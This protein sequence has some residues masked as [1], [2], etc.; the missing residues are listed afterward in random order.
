MPAKP[1]AT[2]KPLKWHRHLKRWYGWG[3][4]SL[5]VL[6]LA[7][8]F[9]GFWWFA[10]VY[11]QAHPLNL[12]AYLPKFERFMAKRGTPVKVGSAELYFDGGPVVRMDDIALMGP[13]GTMAVYVEQAGI[14]LANRRLLLL[15]LSPKVIE[16]QNVTLRLVADNG[17]MSV[18]GMH[19]ASDSNTPM[20]SV[21]GWLNGLTHD[22]VWGRLKT[23]RVAN[24]NLLVKDVQ[25]NTEWV[26]ER[27]DLNIDR[28]P[29]VGEDGTLNG[30]V[31]RLQDGKTMVVQEAGPRAGPVGGR[32]VG[33]SGSIV[34]SQ[35]LAAVTPTLVSGSLVSGSSFV[36][37]ELTIPRTFERGAIPVLVKFRH[38]PDAEALSID[39]RLDRADLGLVADYVPEQFR[40]FLRA[41][42][43]IE[44]G[45]RLLADNKFERP[46]VTLR[47]NNVSVMP[48]KG[49]SK[50]LKFPHV[51]L[52]ASYV[53]P[54]K[55]VS[56]GDVLYLNRVRI[57]G[58]RGNEWMVSGTVSDIT[59]DPY[60]DLALTSEKGDP[61]GIFDFFP[62]ENP[63]MAKALKWLRP[64]IQKAEYANLRAVVK[65]RASS[66]P[67]CADKCGVIEIDA[68]VAKGQVKFL[69]EF[70]PAIATTSGTF[71][72]R[73]NVFTVTLP[74]AT[75][76]DQQATD[77]KVSLNN[78]FTAPEVPVHVMVS[79]SVV[80]PLQGVLKELAAIPEAQGK[81]PTTITG[82]QDSKISVLIPLPHGKEANFAMSTVMVSSTVTGMEARDLKELNGSVYTA[83]VANV[84]LDEGKNLH[85]VASGA[86][87]GTPLKIDLVQGIMPGQFNPTQLSLNGS[88]PAAWLMKRGIDAADVSLTGVFGV[89]ANLAETKPDVWRFGVNADTT[90]GLIRI[91]QLNFTKPQGSKMT[92][93][94]QGIFG[95]GK[96]V[97]M[98]SLVVQGAGANVS[99]T[100]KIDPAKQDDMVVR[101]NPFV[102]GDTNAVVNYANRK[103]VINGKKL[104]LRGLDIFG[105][106]TSS[107]HIVN[108]Q[109][110]ANVD[111][112]ATQTGTLNAVVA[113]VRGVDGRWDIN[114]F[115]AKVNDKANV[116]VRLVP[117]A[118][119]GQRRKLTV[120]IDDLGS[121]LRAMGLYANLNG[122][123]LNGEMTYDTPEVGGGTFVLKGFSLDN[124]PIVMKLL[125][126]LSLEQLLSGTNNVLFDR[127][128]LPVRVDNRVWNL[129]N[130]TFEGPS[131]SIR[132]NGNYDSRKEQMSFN[133]NLAPAIPFNRL[134]SKIPL[135]GT[136]LTG[137][138][139]GVVVADFRLTGPTSNPDVSVKPLSVLTPGLVKDLW[140]GL[141][142]TPDV[143]PSPTV[144]DGRSKKK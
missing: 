28:Y 135:L 2:L 49:F 139:D 101:L 5:I 116:D 90:R 137:S 74:K 15:A 51:Y 70:S 119:Q 78:M 41:R 99:G 143:K 23:V 100:V 68:D 71:V 72:W 11:T 26:W 29:D 35:T 54:A 115:T 121:T 47:L 136:I 114:R 94:A 134:V 96:M 122:G 132:L 88:V 123:R 8:M 131:M 86:M 77:V 59:T 9:G 38:E 24:L 57:E 52:T 133:G 44:V 113:D 76:G 50:A 65:A 103:A 75:V 16:A 102:L 10:Q 48:P 17:K 91:R 138:Q 95:P 30:V 3:P 1:K 53:P 64:N 84:Q 107:T 126:L 112:V 141:T 46:W 108:V 61:Q 128:S 79:A 31:R 12:D 106:D 40:D 25:H 36:G 110:T 19:F 127:A 97:D 92:V 32:S 125:G 45:T 39:A 105:G 34:I 62:D 7:A 130:A 93:R 85:V 55:D 83:D 118:G 142:A 60:F 63:G 6:L 42:G 89:A 87:D 22:R 20:P 129:D 67:H 27:S 117:L 111:E 58:A 13:D 66:F 140:R 81:V 124:A 80:G 37:G 43:R 33:I 82:K 73:S 109:A 120:A 69:D 18:A 4:I 56:G 14:R 104:D 21:V 98:N 144:I